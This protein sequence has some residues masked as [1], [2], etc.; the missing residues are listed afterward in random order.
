MKAKLYVIL[1]SHACRTAMLMLEHKG[2]DYERVELPT[3]MHPFLL[4]LRGFGSNPESFR[5]VD[6]DRPHRMLGMLDRLGTVPSLQIDGQRIKTNRAI[7][8]FIEEL[9]PEPPLFPADQ[10]HRQAVE[11]AE[12]WGDEVFQMTARRLLLAARLQGRDSL[13]NR[14]DDGRLG[15]LLFRSQRTRLAATLGIARI[16][17]ADGAALNELPRALPAMLDRV[18]GWIE[19]GV[20]GGDQ[21]NAADFMI[22]TSWALLTYRRDLR[23]E[24]EGRP[25]MRLVD[26][27]LPEPGLMPGSAPSA[28]LSTR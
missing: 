25:A 16:F 12:R 11:Q 15:P 14:G 4:P 9:R 18:D 21:L 3:G 5:Q 13:I 19:S 7:A 10:E 20:L 1:G 8:R 26:R 2:I 27:L 6:D 23:P 22:A 17:G 28:R 24:L